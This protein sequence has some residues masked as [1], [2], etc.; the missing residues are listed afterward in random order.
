MPSKKIEHFRQLS[1]RTAREIASTPERWT[2]FLTT[3]GR[4]YKY[5]FHEQLLIF[6]QRP[7]AT[8]CADYELWNHR[9]GRYVRRG[10]RGI[11]LLDNTGDRLRLRYV[12]DVT[13]TG[14]T[15]H[16]RTPWLWQLGEQ[17]KESVTAML[18][19]TYGAAGDNLAQILSGVAQNLTDQYWED[20]NFD[21][22]RALDNSPEVEYDEF[23][24][25]IYFKAAAS[26]SVAYSLLSRCGLHPEERFK[27]D[28]FK[29]LTFFQTPAAVMELGNA[30]STI[31]EGVLR[32][33]EAV[34]RKY[35]RE[36]LTERLTIKSQAT[37]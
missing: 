20:G 2:A 37:K 32:Q 35:E 4:L 21:Y 30:V 1:E 17:H 15:P 33:L 34:I 18:E 8:A 22:I 36:R 10:G 19:A 3:A 26:V 27:A 5:P 31:S 23:T 6:A 11:A 28:D 24:I 16:S 9:M 25:G 14:T 7:E 29:A 13:D 12:F